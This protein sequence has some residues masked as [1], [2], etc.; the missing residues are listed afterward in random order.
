MPTRACS[1]NT[2][3]SPS[4][5]CERRCRR[6]RSSPCDGERPQPWRGSV[7]WWAWRPDWPAVR[8]RS[9]AA[10][11]RSPA[12]CSSRSPWRGRC[13]LRPTPILPLRSDGHRPGSRD[14]ARRRRW[15]LSRPARDRRT[16]SDH[17]RMLEAVERDSHAALTQ[18]GGNLSGNPGAD[19]RHYGRALDEISPAPEQPEWSWAGPDGRL[20]SDS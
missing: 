10:C 18:H 16:R 5:R 8:P 9:P 7:R 14:S 20:G 6:P 11:L 12:P 19:T 17:D 13:P 15:K 3:N 4:P 2:R 1:L